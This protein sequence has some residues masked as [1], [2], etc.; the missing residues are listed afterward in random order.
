[1]GTLLVVYGTTEGHTRKIAARIAE[2]AREHGHVAHVI[3]ATL[4][5]SMEAYDAVVVAASLHQGRH[6]ASVEHYVRDHRPSLKAVPTALFS[7][8]LT[9]ALPEPEHQAEAQAC[10]DRF[11]EATGWW[12]EMT[13]LT[14]GALMYTQYDFVKRLLMKMI[15]RRHGASTDTEHDHEFTDWA[16][17]RRDTE[18]FLALL[19][20]RAAPPAAAAVTC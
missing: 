16:K 4:H 5:P 18:A 10:V 3:D 11:T 12:P 8:S 15:A 14:A 19:P 20:A 7:V 6:Q 13:F 17:L 2:T 9:A 1:M